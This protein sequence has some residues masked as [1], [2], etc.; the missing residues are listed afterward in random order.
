MPSSSSQKLEVARRGDLC[1]L[2]V[3]IAPCKATDVPAVR[4]FI[5]SYA[6]TD[7]RLARDE[8]LLWWQ[9]LGERGLP[10]DAGGPHLLLAWSGNDLTGIQGLIPTRVAIRGEPVEAAWLANLLTSPAGRARGAGI[11]LLAAAL[12]VGHPALFSIGITKDLVKALPRLRYEVA[13]SVPRW[14][15]IVDHERAASLVRGGTKAIA[16]LDA[17]SEET[18]IGRDIEVELLTSLD[19]R[20]DEPWQAMA[21]AGVTGTWRDSAYLRW[22]YLDHIAFTYQVFGASR[23]G[24]PVGLLVLRVEQVHGR[25]DIVVRI[26]DL[27]GPDDAVAG[28]ARASLAEARSRSACFV[29]CYTTGS[30]NGLR[31]AGFVAVQADDDPVPSR[32][33]P[34]V[35]I[36]RPLPG[37]VWLEPARRRTGATLV[38][39]LVMTKGDGDMDRPN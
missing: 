24:Q 32:F 33:R 21:A 14:V 39:S 30:A 4:R 9:F 26:V 28:L 25:D 5:S 31:A 23:R 6:R 1:R 20:W 16:Q 18:A 13:H 29:D 8:Q 17:I 27:V 38:G 37:A 19:E 22:R 2:T 10:N 15:A 12:R 34:L 7:H 11:G 3:E 36:S 35:P